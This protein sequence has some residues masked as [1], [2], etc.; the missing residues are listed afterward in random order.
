MTDEKLIRL[1]DRLLESNIEKILMRLIIEG[2][3]DEEI[4]DKLLE[5][6]IC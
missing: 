6:K 5:E 1:F 3:T 4:I 2:K